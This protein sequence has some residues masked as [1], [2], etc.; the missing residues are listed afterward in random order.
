MRLAGYISIG[1]G[2]K[3][4]SELMNVRPE[5]VRQARW[6]LRKTLGLEDESE[7]FPMLSRM[8]GEGSD[9]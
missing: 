4:I 3:E 5:S 2:T 1:L 7:L 6:R 8:L 9:R